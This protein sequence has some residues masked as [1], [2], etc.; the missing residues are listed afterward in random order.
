MSAL[1]IVV[2]VV[3][4]VIAVGEMAQIENLRAPG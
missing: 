2:G 4:T 3:L 1:I